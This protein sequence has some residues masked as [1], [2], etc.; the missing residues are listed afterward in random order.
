MQKWI[1]VNKDRAEH[2]ASSRSKAIRTEAK[3]QDCN[4]GSGETTSNIFHFTFSMISKERRTPSKTNLPKIIPETY[5]EMMMLLDA[6]RRLRE[7][8]QVAESLGSLM[9]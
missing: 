4:D 6:R 5:A 9:M 8:V 7:S 1:I 2:K 3:V